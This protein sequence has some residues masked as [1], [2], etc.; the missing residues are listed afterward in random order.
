MQDILSV[1]SVEEFTAGDENKPEGYVETKGPVVKEDQT[2]HADSAPTGSPVSDGIPDVPMQRTFESGVEL[3]LEDTIE[4][5]HTNKGVA[6]FDLDLS[7][8]GMASNNLTQDENDSNDNSD[9][10]EETVTDDE[11]SIVT[12]YET[13]EYSEESVTDDGEHTADNSESMKEARST[14]DHVS[15]E[16]LSSVSYDSAEEKKEKPWFAGT[17]GWFG[18]GGEELRPVTPRGLI[19]SP[20]STPKSPATAVNVTNGHG[21]DAKVLWVSPFQ[22]ERPATETKTQSPEGGVSAKSKE[23]SNLSLLD[24]KVESNERMAPVCENVKSPILPASGVGLDTTASNSEEAALRALI[25]NTAEADPAEKSDAQDKFS[26]SQVQFRYPY[27]VPPKVPKPRP[28]SEIIKDYSLGTPERVVRWVQPK[29][30]LEELLLAVKGDSMPRRSNACGALKVLLARQPKNVFA[31]VRTVG[32]LEALV[33]ACSEDVISSPE[34]ETALIARSRAATTIMKVSEPKE[35]RVLVTTEPGLPECLVKVVME[36]TGEARAHAC[37]AL[38]MLAKTPANRELMVDVKDLVNVL[39][40]VVNGAIN[41]TLGP[42]VQEE[43]KEEAQGPFGFGSSSFTSAGEDSCDGMEAMSTGA[44]SSA[45]PPVSTVN[46]R[47]D[48]IRKHKD[49]K[50]EEYTMQS[51]HH[52]CATLMHLSKHCPISVSHSCISLVPFHFVWIILFT[53]F[54]VSTGQVMRESDIDG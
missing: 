4:A 34:M 6:S 7:E 40:Q 54:L 21:K 23:N 20:Q 44:S 9:Y 47:P 41:L 22:V 19:G 10:T 18:G 38:A 32:F 27:P 48:S 26:A 36:D 3:A 28:A 13:S 1:S 16:Q 30:E 5:M 39:A 46:F 53:S 51:K 12:D 29:P 37:A 11:N 42:A 50:Q 17:R 14:G 52:A 15:S 49:G 24:P 33:F 43:K 31:L 25:I 8:T 2:E 35:N 45:S